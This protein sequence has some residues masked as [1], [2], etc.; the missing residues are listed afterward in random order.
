MFPTLSVSIVP[1]WLRLKKRYQAAQ[2]HLFAVLPRLRPLTHK[3]D[4]GVHNIRHPEP[5]GEPVLS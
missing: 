1:Q 3:A 2:K 5:E 4:K